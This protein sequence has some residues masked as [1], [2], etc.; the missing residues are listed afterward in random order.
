MGFFS[1]VLQSRAIKQTY[2][3]SV[4]QGGPSWLSGSPEVWSGAEVTELTAL[5]VSAYY[6]CIRVIAEDLSS[7]PLPVYER[8][9]PRGKRR[10]TK[11]RLYSI[12]HDEPNAWMTSMVRRE[13]ELYHV[14]GWGN[15]YSFIEKDGA[16]N[17]MAIWPLRPDMTCAEIYEGRLR[18]RTKLFKD[19]EKEE[20]FAPEEVLHIPGLGFD[21]LRGYTTAHLMRQSL[22]LTI[23]LE[24]SGAR[25][26]GNG[27]Q[28]GV[29][30][31]HPRQ[32]SE[33]AQARL[34]SNWIGTHGGL[35]KR[36]LPA[37]L[38]EGMKVSK[39]GIPPDESQFIET[40]QFQ[41]TETCRF[42]RMQPHKIAHLINATFSNIEHQAIE[43]VVD[44]LRPWAVRTE[45]EY[46]RK[47]FSSQQRGRFFVEHLFDG[48]LRGDA[49]TRADALAV[50]RQN[51]TINAD[52]WREIE[53]ENPLPDGQ[54]EIYVVQSGM[55]PL[56]RV[57]ENM[58]PA[59][60]APDPAPAKKGIDPAA[61][62]D[63]VAERVLARETKRLGGAITKI[64]SGGLAGFEE[65]SLRFYIDHANYVARSILPLLR[66]FGLELDRA[67]SIARQH[68]NQSLDA[69]SRHI[70]AADPKAMTRSLTK[71]LE[72]W[73]AERPAELR[74]RIEAALE[75]A[76]ERNV[77]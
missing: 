65:W 13:T 5:G 73:A 31:E 44:T 43:H 1:E 50:R 74:T 49:K 63:D 27:A 62:I 69:L 72:I 67:D 2:A 30:L 20:I 33:A 39:L 59:S 19:P 26:F 45:Q 9:D 36:H 17:V 3:Q 24:E 11:H 14:L 23:A 28:H 57:G 66:T 56:G 71:L 58:P 75:S 61:L 48:L 18:Y 60:P 6:A 77:A 25:Y 46:N 22:G 51:G 34:K 16:N 47:L 38:E 40:R 55:I 4:Q 52:E 12:V 8:L 7:L 10:A 68:V 15:A 76:V 70:A 32:L 53:N 35:S 54:G 21:G 29:A 41:V 64:E 42:F 37:I